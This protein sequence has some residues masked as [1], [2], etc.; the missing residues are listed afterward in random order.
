MRA[1]TLRQPIDRLPP[2]W[3]SGL[4]AREV[5]FTPPQSLVTFATPPMQPY[6]QIIPPSPRLAPFIASMWE[7]NVD[8]PTARTIVGKLLPSIAP[9]LALH[10]G[11]PMWSNRGPAAGPYRQIAT[12]IQTTPVSVHATGPVRAVIVRLKPE[13]APL[14]FAAAL[15]ELRDTQVELRDFFSNSQVALLTERLAAAECTRERALLVEAFLLDRIQTRG[16]DP[17]MQ[18]AALDLRRDFQLPVHQLAADLGL[19]ERQLLRYFRASFGLS[20]KQFS[21]IVRMTRALAL[22][23]RGK[24]TWVQIASD[25]GFADQAH[26]IR[27][28]SA[29][30]QLAPET[31]LRMTAAAAL[32]PLN[33]TLSE[34]ELSNTFVVR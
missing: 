34:S 19:S 3:P 4:D 10:Y 21:R 25:C 16:F 18:Q 8:G 24:L 5:W 17:R 22:R 14:I 15:H 31:L 20:P 33:E 26:L 12:G 1:G 29:L 32:Q 23:R 11:A 30:T 27:D 6:L 28:F 13:A 2:Q 9:Q 7:W